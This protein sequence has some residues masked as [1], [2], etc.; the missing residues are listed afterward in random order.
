[1]LGVSVSHLHQII[2]QSLDMCPQI[3]RVQQSNFCSQTQTLSRDS[4]DDNDSTRSFNCDNKQLLA[5][6]SLICE[7]IIFFFQYICRQQTADINLTCFVFG[8]KVK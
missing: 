2:S 1:M 8:G 4:D 3:F 5:E 7:N 6:D